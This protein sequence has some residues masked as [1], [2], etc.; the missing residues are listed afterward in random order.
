MASNNGSSLETGFQVFREDLVQLVSQPDLIGMVMH[1]GGSSDSDSESETS[2][3]EDETMPAGHAR[4]CWLSSDG[5]HPKKVRVQDVKVL[6]RAFMHGDPVAWAADPLGQLGTVADVQLVVDLEFADGRILRDVDSKNL[7]RVRPFVPGGFVIH[8]FWVGRVE[9]VED[10]VTVLFDDGAKC[11]FLR[12][13]PDLIQPMQEDP[14]RD[15]DYPYYPGQRVRA[16]STRLFRH[17]KWLRGKGK[18][19]EGVVVGVDPATVVVDWVAAGSCPS[20]SLQPPPAPHQNPR[21]LWPL[22]YF[23]HTEWQIGDRSLAPV[24]DATVSDNGVSDYHSDSSCV[25]HPQAGNANATSGGTG[26]SSAAAVAAAVVAAAGGSHESRGFRKSKALR[27]KV[28]P[29]IKFQKKD[30]SVDPSSSKDE[31]V[32]TAP[33]VVSTRT[34]VDIIWQDGTRSCGVNSCLVIPKGHFGEHEFW[35]EQY[36]VERGSDGEGVETESRRV[37]VV[38]SVDSR[39]RTARVRWLKPRSFRGPIEWEGEEVVS[40]YELFEHSEYSYSLGDL[41]IRQNPDTYD[42]SASGFK[43]VCKKPGKSGVSTVDLRGLSWVGCIIGLEGGELEVAWVNGSVSKVK[44]REVAIFSRDDDDSSVF[45]NESEGSDE[46]D[47][48]TSSWVTADSAD[49][50][51]LEDLTSVPDLASVAPLHM[52]PVA[53]TPDEVD[54]SGL[55]CLEETPAPE[56]DSEVAAASSDA[57]VVQPR[58][59]ETMRFKHFDSVEEAPRD[60]H[61]YLEAGHLSNERKWSK[62][63][64]QEWSLME[65]N[66]PDTIYVRVYEDRMDVLR[67][68]IV[69]VP[70]TPYNSGLFV[71]DFFLPPEF[72]MVPPIAYYHSGGLRLNPNLYENGKVCLSLLNTWTGTGTEVWNPKTSTILQ[73][74]LSI[75]ALV[76]NEKPY[77]NEA[78]YEKQVGTGEGEK[79]AVI[80][81]ENTFLLCCKTMLYQLH[82]PPQNF[83]QLIADH[84]REEGPKIVEACNSYLSGAQVCP[85]DQSAASNGDSKGGGSSAGFKLMLAKILPK[86]RD[87]FTGIGAAL[88]GI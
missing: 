34:T 41:V 14:M 68:V 29:K 48:E 1:V 13:E 6:D 77:F 81:N 61:Y 7:A 87:A 69:G 64:Q 54:D 43:G 32:E 45:N 3:A 63:V 71:F 15:D 70:G 88:N 17:A 62:R 83:E 74:L 82:R 35:P 73:V 52:T 40:V 24:G 80:Y 65:K 21:K 60:H 33:R 20:T 78:G 76:L 84:Y 4:I 46:D 10:N 36:V 18:K 27:V 9:Y 23:S 22:T 12:V 11:K 58:A 56:H 5:C 25:E 79:N 55:L 50:A 59:A 86:L 28:D 66:L 53:G 51:L 16:T 49:I 39:Q 44:P 31:V 85:D 2:D 75:Q 57:T 67:A 26:L 19:L 42:E 47:D 72:P 30:E 38:Q 37:G 8:D